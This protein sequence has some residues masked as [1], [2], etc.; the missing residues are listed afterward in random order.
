MKFLIQSRY[1]NICKTKNWFWQSKSQ[2]LL[3]YFQETHKDVELLAK[4]HV[5]DLEGKGEGRE[6]AALEAGDFVLVTRETSVRREGATRFQDK[7]YPEI[8]RIKKG[9]QHTFWVEYVGK[10]DETPPFKQPLPAARLIKLDLPRLDLDPNQPRR[11]EIQRP[12]SDGREDGWEKW[13]IEK[14]AADGQVQLRQEDHPENVEW[15]DLSE[16]R[17]RWLA[18]G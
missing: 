13:K 8:F 12:G 3:A 15:V 9:F 17:Y 10:K 14:F 2:N 1:Q 18:G 6:S 5:E 4:E 7:T 11:L 16:K